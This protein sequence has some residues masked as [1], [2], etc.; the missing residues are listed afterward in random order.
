M[1]VIAVSPKSEMAA[2]RLG[3]DVA[4][5]LTKALETAREFVGPDSKVCYF[6]CP[7]IFM[8]QVS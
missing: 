8:S 3:F 2:Q 1:E 6:H 4:P 7:P 5:S